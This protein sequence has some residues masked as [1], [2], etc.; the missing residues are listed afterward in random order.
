MSASLPV[1]YAAQGCGSMLV[2]MALDWVGQPFVRVGM[3]WDEVRARANAELAR[4]NPLYQIPTL[5]WPDGLVQTES[6]A[7]VLWLDEQHPTAGLLPPRGS[8][9]RWRAL[10]AL[11]F[12]NTALYPTFSYA[13]FPERYLPDPAAQAQL[14]AGVEARRIWLWEQFA[15]ELCGPAST[16]RTGPWYAGDT[17]CIVDGYIAVMSRWHPRRAYFAEHLPQLHAIAVAADSHPV[18][19]LARLRNFPPH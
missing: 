12:L 14:V 3:T 5:H 11:M 10:R 8:A 15:A 13:D 17:A 2:E 18:M 7:I 19:Q 9:E 1:L 16:A 4:L 6:A